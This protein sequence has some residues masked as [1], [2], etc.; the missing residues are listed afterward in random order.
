MLGFPVNVSAP[1]PNNITNI[2]MS[3]LLQVSNPYLPDINASGYCFVS[4]SIPQGHTE[5]MSRMTQRP[6]DVM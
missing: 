4:L 6:N 2:T 3:H 1:S 5:V